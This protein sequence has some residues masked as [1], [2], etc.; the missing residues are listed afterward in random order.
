MKD[1]KLIRL[2]ITL[3]AR[4]FRRFG[5]FV[6]SPYFNK[7]KNVIALF[8]VIAS[9]YPQFENRNF[10][11]EKVYKKIFPSEKFDLSGFKNYISDLYHLSEKFLAYRKIENREFYIERNI[12]SELRGKG[13]YSIYEQKYNTY[14]K[15]LIDRKYKDE[16]YFYYLYEMNDEYLWY[17]T[18]KK[19]NTEFNVLQTEFDH[20]F[21]YA[22]IRL[23]RFYNLMLHERN[24]NNINYR[25]TMFKE[26]LNYITNEQTEEIPAILVF[27]TILLLLHTKD[28]KHYLELWELK[29]KYIDE[30]RSDDRNLIYIHLYDFAAYMV[31]FKNDDSY[32]YDMFKIYKEQIDKKIM[33]PEGFHYYNFMNVVKIACRIGEYGYAENFIKEFRS[34]IPK[35]EETN[36]LEFCYGTIENAKGNS[37][38]ALKHFSKTNFQN[39]ILKVQVKIVL[40]KSYFKLEMYEQALGM[41]DSFRHYVSREENLL[42]EHKE[43]YNKFLILVS[44]LIKVKESYSKDK[45]F[46]LEKLKREAGLMPANPFRIKAWLLEEISKS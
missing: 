1:L 24:Q 33:V 3:D 6:H 30:F 23:L 26:I 36:V 39:F 16:D 37:K 11:A 20:F 4:E 12:F 7:N 25:L 41:I 34:S 35:D 2:L 22:L 15:E 46:E 27:K 28:K 18:I 5:E 8:K 21:N 29:E 10:T 38:N 19:P 17:A 40:L 45:S 13:L 31:N 43:S 44:D 14:M 32:N 42:K 9:Y